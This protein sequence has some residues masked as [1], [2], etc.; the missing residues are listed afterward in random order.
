VGAYHV[1]VICFG[2]YINLPTPSV[3]YFQNN[4]AAIASKIHAIIV[5]IDR[6]EDY[7]VPFDR[8]IQDANA[9][10]EFLLN[11]GVHKENIQTFERAELATKQEIMKK[12]ASLK[13]NANR[14]DPII[15]YYSGFMGT[16]KV[17]ERGAGM[18]C[19]YDV[20]SHKGGISDTALV[21]MFDELALFCGNNIVSYV[22]PIET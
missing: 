17:G 10:R 15:F 22:I 19:P 5:A 12:V 11:L 2:H 8:A 21:Q 20:L 16:T 13:E 3:L 14:G 1:S 4:M 7:D 18:I 6:Y 9:M